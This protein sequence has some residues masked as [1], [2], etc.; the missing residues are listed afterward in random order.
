MAAARVP[1]MSAERAPREPWHDPILRAADRAVERWLPPGRLRSGW[2]ESRVWLAA[3]PTLFALL[4][5]TQRFGVVR[6]GRLGVLINDARVGRAIL[7]DPTRFRTVGPGTHGELIDEVIGPRGLLNMDGPDH[8][9]LRRTMADLFSAA[10][11]A[12]IAERVSAGAL[13]AAA[14]TL[15]NG[16][17]VDLARLIRIITGRTAYALLGAPDPPDGDAGYLRTYR[18][19]EEL[20]AMTVDGARR[21]LRPRE[22]QRA[23]D[24]VAAMAAGARAGWD[25]DGDS[26]LARLRRLGFGYD[27]AR[28]LVVVIILAGTE[29]VSSGL[30]RSLALLIDTGTWDQIPPDDPAAIDDAIDACLRLVTPSPMIVRCCV[31]PTQI[32]GHRFRRGQR[33]LISVHG[34]TRTRA[35]FGGRDPGAL[36]VGEPIH[37]ELRHLWFGAGP[38]FCIGSL[39]A[40]AEL[41][42]VLAMLRARGPLT[43]VHRRPSRGVL[44]PSYA[45]F[46]VRRS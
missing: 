16:G 2:W 36:A 15:D 41:R 4:R 9:S 24:L 37:R 11:S 20:V 23:E 45:E 33:I 32:R 34:M 30:P 14:A 42:A 7:L 6:L 35:L 18:L 46:I 38:H 21:G 27:E 39:L 8:E 28:A 29:T 25:A 5:F 43:V 31:E 40:R 1:S 12:G 19:G 17:T 22:K 3:D 10:S 26:A 13:A 44:F